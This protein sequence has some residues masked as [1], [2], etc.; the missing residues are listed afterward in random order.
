MSAFEVLCKKRSATSLVGIITGLTK[1]DV[2]FIDSNTNWAKCSKMCGVVDAT[3]T[4]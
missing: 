4:P 1:D 3:S 2:Y